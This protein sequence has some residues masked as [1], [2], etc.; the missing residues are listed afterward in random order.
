MF[1]LVSGRRLLQVEVQIL[2]ITGLKLRSKMHFYGRVA[3]EEVLATF[4]SALLRPGPRRR[5][6]AAAE[7][8]L[9]N[10]RSALLRPRSGRSGFSKLQQSSL[11]I[12]IQKGCV[13]ALGVP[14]RGARAPWVGP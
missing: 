10:C 8:V 1:G 7:V 13:G 12:L 2:I 4:L 3:A 9:A 6:R 14:L 11:R 5:G